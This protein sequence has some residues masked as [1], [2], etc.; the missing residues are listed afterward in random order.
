MICP[1][2]TMIPIVTW[3]LPSSNTESNS[4]NIRFIFQQVV[5]TVHKGRPATLY[6]QT[7]HDDMR[8]T[9]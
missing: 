7:P 5:I 9:L 2:N 3:Q 8:P 6:K 4:T 1:Q